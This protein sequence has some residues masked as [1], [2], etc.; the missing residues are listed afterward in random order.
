V[1]PAEVE[2][3]LATHPAVER[4]AVTGAPDPVLGEIGVAIVV[5]KEGARVD[6]AGMRARC[7]EKLSDYK[8]PDALVLVDEI[9]LTPM[10]KVDTRQLA[11]LA[12]QAAGDRLADRA[13]RGQ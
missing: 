11:L 5:A 7:A 4:V 6:L 10:M 2:E 8:V 1:Y 13:R 12:E 3:V 9:P